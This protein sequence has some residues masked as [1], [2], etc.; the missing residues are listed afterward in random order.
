MILRTTRGSLTPVPHFHGFEFAQRTISSRADSIDSQRPLRNVIFN[1]RFSNL[2]KMQLRYL[3]L[4]GTVMER[5]PIRGLEGDRPSEDRDGQD[6]E[7]R[8]G[9]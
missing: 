3:V 1:G 9:S 8:P 6:E 7:R 5:F 2:T 4:H